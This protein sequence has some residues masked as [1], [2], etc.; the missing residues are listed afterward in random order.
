MRPEAF[1]SFQI[2]PPEARFFARKIAPR[3]VQGTAQWLAEQL[4]AARVGEHEQV[5]GA[6]LEAQ[7]YPGPIEVS[8][9]RDT[10]IVLDLNHPMAGKDLVFDIEIIDVK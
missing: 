4:P 6:Q 10:V 5:V 1:T 8:E 2:R 7:N 9:V 3:D